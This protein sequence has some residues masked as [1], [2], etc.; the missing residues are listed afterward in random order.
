MSNS[1]ALLVAPAI[2]EVEEVPWI[3]IGQD[4]VADQP[5]GAAPVARLEPRRH[6]RDRYFV[7]PRGHLTAVEPDAVPLPPVDELE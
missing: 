4:V 5:P 3:E 1:A 7:V 6:G 2:P